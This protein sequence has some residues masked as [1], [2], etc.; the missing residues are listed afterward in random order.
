MRDDIYTYLYKSDVRLGLTKR[1]AS[2]VIDDEH[3]VQQYRAPE[4]FI[5]ASGDAR[6]DGTQLGYLIAAVQYQQEQIE[7]LKKKLEEKTNG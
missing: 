2:L 3:D 1:H 6:D 7:E 5:T 4:E